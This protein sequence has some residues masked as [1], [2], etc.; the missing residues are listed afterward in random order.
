MTNF[1]HE[2]S[3]VF[4]NIRCASKRREE[5][6]EEIVEQRAEIE[7]RQEKIL[8]ITDKIAHEQLEVVEKQTK[9]AQKQARVAQEQAEIA[10]EQEEIAYEQ[11]NIAQ[12]Q[13]EIAKERTEIAQVQAEIQK[14]DS[15]ISKLSAVDAGLQADVTGSLDHLNE[16]GSLKPVLV[17][18]DSPSLTVFWGKGNSLLLTELQYAI[19]EILYH[20]PECQMSITCL[21]ERVW[22]KDTLPTDGAAKVAVSRL[23][24][25]LNDADFPL[26]V[27]RIKREL[28]TVPVQHPVTKAA[29]DV[30]VQPEIELYKLVRR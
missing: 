10:C 21:E 27:T 13:A 8:G 2:Q 19:V 20:A 29:M 30:T 1:S 9:V 15:E 18:F 23:N 25:V 6:A 24:K 16:D 4:N 7:K 3:V 22:G 14:L 11:E 12:E 17:Q 26:E 5:I 28:K